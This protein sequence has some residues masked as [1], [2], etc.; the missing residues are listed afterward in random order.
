[1]CCFKRRRAH[2]NSTKLL[3]EEL[4]KIFTLLWVIVPLLTPALLHWKSMSNPF[5]IASP[6]PSASSLLFPSF[7]ILFLSPAVIDLFVFVSCPFVVSHKL[8]LHCRNKCCCSSSTVTLIPA[9]SHFLPTV[10]IVTLLI[11]SE[12]MSY[13]CIYV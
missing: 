1:M 9:K 11:V 8:I 13:V 6:L 2:I 10:V 7:Y 4:S 12:D 5:F 3:S